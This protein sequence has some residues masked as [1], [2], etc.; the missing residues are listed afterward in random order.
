M[1]GSRHPAS[2]FSP[3]TLRFPVSFQRSPYRFP[4]LRRGFHRH[5]H[6]LL[7][8]Q[9]LRKQLQLLGVASVPASLELIFVFDFNVS[10]HHGQLL[11]VDVN[12]G[13]PIRHRLP[14]GG[15]GER[16]GDFIKQGLGL[17]PLPQG[18]RQRTIYSLYHARSGSHTLTASASPL[19]SQSRRS[20]RCG[21]L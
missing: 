6:D 1:Q 14:P 3:L 13:Y 9:P 21:V 7:L 15:S 16:A 4:I 18:E 17:S 2:T 5:F 10:H 8:D 20:S 11:F 12:S 19:S